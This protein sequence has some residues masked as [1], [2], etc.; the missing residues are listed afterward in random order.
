MFSF[1]I[2]TAAN[3]A[4]AFAVVHEHGQIIGDVNH[5]SILVAKNGTVKL[6]DCDSF[7]IA[8]QGHHYLCQVGVPTHTPPELQNQSF[9]GIIRNANHYAFGLA[10]I[11]FQLLFMGRHPFSGRYLGPGDMPMERAISEYRFAYCPNA[12]SHQ[13]RPPP[14]TLPLEA[15]SEPVANLFLAAFSRNNVRPRADEWVPAS[16]E[17]S[18]NLNQC[19]H[20][21]GHHFL[22]SLSSCPVVQDRSPSRY[23]FIQYCL[24]KCDRTKL[25]L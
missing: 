8:A 3:I 14:G 12:A 21:N 11:I 22:K 23:H 9:H 19:S 16:I 18:K 1:P 6:I 5:A 15:I 4:R 25:H 17:L 13:M 2:N 20:N 7:Q 24:C 10:V